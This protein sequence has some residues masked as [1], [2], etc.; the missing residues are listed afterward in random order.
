MTLDKL[1]C[2]WPHICHILIFTCS[3]RYLD[4]IRLFAVMSLKSTL[5][6][7]LNW[8]HLL[9]TFHRVLHWICL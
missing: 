4:E 1:C 2:F 8:F 9:G 5:G 6:V 7:S 3:V